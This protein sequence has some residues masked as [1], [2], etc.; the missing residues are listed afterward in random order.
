MKIDHTIDYRSQTAAHFTTY[1]LPPE[2]MRIVERNRTLLSDIA[3]NAG[4]T[5]AREAEAWGREQMLGTT[6]DRVV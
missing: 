4:N 5:I 3:T 2:V 1:A 6:V